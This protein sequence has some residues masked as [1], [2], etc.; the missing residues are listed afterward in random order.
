MGALEGRSLA[1]CG[2]RLCSADGDGPAVAVTVLLLAGDRS[3]RCQ[4]LQPGRCHS[5]AGQ[6]SGH[7]CASSGASMPQKA[8]RDAV[9]LEGV[10]ICDGRG[11]GCLQTEHHKCRDGRSPASRSD[12]GDAHHST[13][14]HQPL[15][16]QFVRAIFAAR[17]PSVKPV[18]SVYAFWT[19]RRWLAS[20]I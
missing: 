18:I 20:A 17:V 9:L 19:Y 1:V 14:Q 16:R 2:H 5:A 15:S 7:V 3:A 8:I 4:Y 6:P 13:S 10:A 12:T 11:G